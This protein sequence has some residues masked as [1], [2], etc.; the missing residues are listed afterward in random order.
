M[1]LAVAGILYGAM[2]AFSQAD[3]KRMVAY[4]SVSHM[5]FVLLGICVWNV[6]SLQGA[7]VQMISHGISTGALF[8]L[9]GILQERLGSRDLGRM[10]GLWGQAP[11]MGGMMLLFSLASLGL[12]GLGNFVGEFLVLLGAFEANIT[13]TA[14]AALGLVA[15]AV[16]ALWLM[17]RA[18]FGRAASG[19]KIK[20]LSL[21]ETVALGALAVVVVVVGIYP[22]P[23]LKTAGQW[24]ES[25]QKPA[26]IE[27]AGPAIA[28]DMP[29]GT[30]ERD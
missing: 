16:Y 30:H 14:M 18:F 13:L 22:R 9:A 5:G 8:V 12:P 29:G 4:P 24:I 19:P 17:Q 20:D 26:A 28:Y 6:I 27:Q 2:M 21:R 25:L 3:L 11:R 15:A 7:V 10:G 23:F 1:A